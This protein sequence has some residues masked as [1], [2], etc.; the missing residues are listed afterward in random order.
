[1]DNCS[2][3]EDPGD[4]VWD[5]ASEI[6]I[7]L[8]G[9]S[10]SSDGSGVVVEGTSVTIITPGNYR[11]SGSLTDGQVLV[12]IQGNTSVTPTPLPKTVSGNDPEIQS[13]GDEIV[14]LIFDGVQIAN[15]TSAPVYINNADK[16]RSC[17]EGHCQLTFTKN[18]L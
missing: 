14:R 16:F 4:Y 2:T 10:I 1:M 13:S 15:T 6:M 8:N 9:N 5:S 7:Q 3:H 11:L 18:L 12:D 17:D